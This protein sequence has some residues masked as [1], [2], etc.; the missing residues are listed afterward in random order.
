MGKDGHLHTH[1]KM[2]CKTLKEEPPRW[3]ATSHL[4][5]WPKLTTQ[6]TTSLGKDAEKGE[7]LLHCWWECELVQ[8]IWKRL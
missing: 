8:P 1:S 3:G 2:S 5:E 4:S 6:E 7:P